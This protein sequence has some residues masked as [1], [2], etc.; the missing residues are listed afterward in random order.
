M[1]PGSIT[2]YRITKGDQVA[3][4]ITLF[5][6]IE[7]KIAFAFPLLLWKIS[8]K[9]VCLEASLLYMT[10][11]GFLKLSFRKKIMSCEDIFKCCFTRNSFFGLS[12]VYWKLTS[13]PI[14]DRPY[15]PHHHLPH[16]YSAT[17]NEDSHDLSTSS[18]CAAGKIPEPSLAL[19]TSL[20]PSD[21]R[22]QS[23]CTRAIIFL[24]KHQNSMELQ[25]LAR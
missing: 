23:R 8:Q 25:S 11:A 13:W 3:R 14:R 20:T 22:T 1:N 7:K 12:T 21:G 17:Y 18:R 16:L 9:V 10:T 4:P 2:E 24:A 19:L 15:P 5:Y 6:I